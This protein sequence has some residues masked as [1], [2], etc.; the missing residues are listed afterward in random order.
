MHNDFVVAA[1]DV[2][3]IFFKQTHLK[4]CHAHSFP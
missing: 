2:K 4:F 1:F 3:Y